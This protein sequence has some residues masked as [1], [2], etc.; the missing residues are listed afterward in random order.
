M[1]RTSR[2]DAG[3][4]LLELLVVLTILVLI[5]ASLPAVL[6]STPDRAETGRAI[7]A[8]LREARMAA[9]TGGRE[10]DFLLDLTARTFGK[11]GSQ[12]ALPSDINLTV[13]SA[14]E[15]AAGDRHAIRFFPDGSASGGRIGVGDGQVTDWIDV[16]WLTGTIRR[17]E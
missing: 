16:N 2:T 8:G 6:S 9:I 11:Q 12:S 17:A 14:R 5:T 13:T 7:M 1:R 10:V 3:L 4:T 15:V